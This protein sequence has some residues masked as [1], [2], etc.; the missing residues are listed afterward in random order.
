MFGAWRRR[1][2]ASSRRKIAKRDFQP[3]VPGRISGLVRQLD[4]DGIQKLPGCCYVALDIGRRMS[5]RSLRPRPG[6]RIPDTAVRHIDAA[7]VDPLE[8]ERPFRFDS[9]L[10]QPWLEAEA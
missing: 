2:A 7:R 9:V 4:H 3:V 6:Y 5:E 8:V 1:D 10:R